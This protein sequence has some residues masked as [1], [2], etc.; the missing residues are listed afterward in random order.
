MKAPRATDE[1]P[2]RNQARASKAKGLAASEASQE[3]SAK[4]GRRYGASKAGFPKK[5]GGIALDPN[6][7][8]PQ[9]SYFWQ[10]F[11]Q[12]PPNCGHR[13]ARFEKHSPHQEQ[14]A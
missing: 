13:R 10:A 2:A 6:I 7:F 14:S 4:T 5:A 12:G 9:S 1:C 8:D 3:N 11:I